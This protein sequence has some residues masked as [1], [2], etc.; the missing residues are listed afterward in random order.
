[1]DYKEAWIELKDRLEKA[2]IDLLALRSVTKDD[3]E[4]ERISHKIFGLR[5]AQQ[6]MMETEMSID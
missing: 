6:Y 2:E 1:M 5:I 4:H 3:T